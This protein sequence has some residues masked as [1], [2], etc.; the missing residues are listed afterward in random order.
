VINNSDRKGSHCLRDP[1]GRLWAID[2]GVTFSPTP[3]LRTVLWGW[4]GEPLQDGDLERLVR[5]E[6]ALR[7]D[8]VDASLRELLPERDVAALRARVGQLLRSRRHPRP[9]PGWPALPW[10]PL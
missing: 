8:V 7:D 1:D 6:E 4:A 3:K 9:H 5:L 2:H 10:P